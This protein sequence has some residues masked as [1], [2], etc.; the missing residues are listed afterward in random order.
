[1]VLPG[2][3][4][5]DVRALIEAGRERTARQ[6]NRQMVS[7]Y[8]RV[9]WRIRKAVLGSKRAAYGERVVELLGRQLSTEYGR[10]FSRFGLSRMMKFA[11]AFDDANIVAT[12]SQQLGWSHFVE[13]LA[14]A[15]KLKRDFYAQMCRQERWSVRTLRDRI[16]GM[17]FE[18]TALCQKPARL[19]R[20]ELDELTQ[21]DRLSAD[22]VFRDPYLLDFLKLQDTYSEH[23][24]E[25]AILRDM[26]RFLLELGTDF[27]FVARQKRMSI[28]G[29][30]FHLDLLFFHR[31][32]RCLVAVELKLGRFAAEHKGQME[33]YLNW[34]ARHELRPEE[35]P[36]IGLVLCSEKNREQIE[37]LKL[38]RTSI[39]VAEYL[40]ALP[41]RALLEARLHQA[42]KIGRERFEAQP[43]GHRFNPPA[44]A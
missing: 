14:I 40:T 3:L 38:D 8:W 5:E 24:L 20:A 30:D 23:D 15:D 25:S 18:R 37:L 35:R 34:L 29:E 42:I 7:L 13:L 32:L 28:G 21:Q 12:L 44:P 2:D 43:A 39:R 36:P 19:A 1:M 31:G 26:E 10:G 9:G 17:L 4:L 6:V 11:S 41:P 22:L 16:R 27:T 33:L